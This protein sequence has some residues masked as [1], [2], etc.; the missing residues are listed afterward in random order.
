MFVEINCYPLFWL[1]F[2][3]DKNTLCA[4]TPC[5]S[6]APTKYSSSF[7]F[8]IHLSL[9]NPFSILFFSRPWWYPMRL[10]K[11]QQS[12]KRWTWC[13]QTPS[14]STMWPTSSTCCG[15]AHCR[16]SFLLFSCG[17]S[18]DRPCWQ[19]WQSWCWWCRSMDCWLPRPEKSRSVEMHTLWG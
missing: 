2:H 7:F 13:R 18:W 8:S 15:P 9:C 16:S 12:A 19:D 17:S 4:W 3:L 6:Q 1:D 5:L 11:S 14:A 10:V